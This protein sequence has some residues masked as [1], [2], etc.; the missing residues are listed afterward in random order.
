MLDYLLC[1]EKAISFVRHLDYDRYRLLMNAHS[2]LVQRL[3]LKSSYS[4]LTTPRVSVLE[5]MSYLT[6]MPVVLVEIVVGYC[7][8]TLDDPEDE[9]E[10]YNNLLASNELE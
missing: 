8:L 9:D 5:L 7:N 1:Y 10:I 4:K 2:Q 6:N 3:E